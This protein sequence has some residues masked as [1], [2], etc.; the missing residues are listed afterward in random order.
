MHFPPHRVH[1]S[2]RGT[3]VLW[4]VPVLLAFGGWLCAHLGWDLMLAQSFYN[5]HAGNFPAR[6]NPILELYGHRGA[7]LFLEC[8]WLALVIA[9]LAT[10]LTPRFKVH[11]RLLWATVFAMIIGPVLVSALKNLTTPVCP[12]DMPRFGGHAPLSDHFWAWDA[13]VGH[14]FPS[15]HAAAG[16]SLIALFMA[17]R[18]TQQRWLETLGLTLALVVGGSLGLLRMVQGAHFLSHTLWSGAIDWVGAWLI[19]WAAGL[20]TFRSNTL[21]HASHPV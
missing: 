8:S 13:P 6:L 12:W 7:R 5:A 16:F 19:F 4:I 14:C 2:H 20:P 21:N 18:A 15:G 9:A 17:G 10:R 11:Q 3:V 1:P